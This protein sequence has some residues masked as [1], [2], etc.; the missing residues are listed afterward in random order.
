MSEP[1]LGTADELAS[2]RSAAAGLAADAGALLLDFFRRPLEVRYKDKQDRN[3][4]TEADSAAE[5]LIRDGILAR[6]G[7]HAVI[8]EETEGFGGEA[9]SPY[10]WVV[11]PLD[12]TANFMNGLALFTVSVGVLHLGRPVV[13][14]IFVPSGVA[15]APAVLSAAR[16]L[17]V[18][19]GHAPVDDTLRRDL[20]L[21]LGALPGGGLRRRGR[22]P[23]GPRL[24]DPRSLGSIALEMAL[25]GMGALQYAVFPRTR[26]WDVAAGTLIIAESGGTALVRG[27][28]GWTSADRFEPDPAV[29]DPME[30][31]R[32]WSRP[33]VVGNEEAVRYLTGLVAERPG[34]VRRILGRLRR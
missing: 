24:G 31:L 10:V 2:I 25:V 17:G 27:S 8:T 18:T 19:F 11:D 23:E 30:G 3:P 29:A 6:F 12:G 28:R 5:A 33:M 9:G 20:S 26:L 13:G 22:R 32:R 4:V 7:D 1:L 14:A 15:G 34:A 16:G 21:R